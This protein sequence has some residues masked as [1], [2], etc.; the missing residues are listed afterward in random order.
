MPIRGIIRS[1]RIF[2]LAIYL[3]VCARRTARLERLVKAGHGNKQAK[4]DTLYNRMGS[5][6][7]K[8]ALQLQGLMVKVGQFLSART[9]VLPTSFTNELRSLQDAVPGVAFEQIRERIEAE[10]GSDLHSNFSTFEAQPLAAASLG[11]VHLASLAKG[12]RV[13]VKVL[14]P[15]IERLAAIDLAALRLITHI[16]QRYSRVGRRMQAVALFKEFSATVHEELDY[17]RE[18]E[19]LLRFARQFSH[20]ADI[21][22]PRCFS[23]YSTRRVL[24]MEY[25]EG[26][27]ITDLEELRAAGVDVTQVVRLLVDSYLEQILEFGFIHVDPHPGNLLVLRDG[28][29]CYLDFGMMSDIPRSESVLFARMFLAAMVRDIDTMIQAIDRLG[30]LQPYADKAVLKRALSYM[31]DRVNGIEI[32]RGPEFDDFKTEFQ[33]FL[34]DEPLILQARYMFLGRALGMVLGLVNT[35][36]PTVKWA[37]LLREKALPKLK[38]IVN[39]ATQSDNA[40]HSASWMSGISDTIQALFGES[41]GVTSRVALKEVQAAITASVRLPQKMDKFVEKL[42]RDG[43]DIRIELNDVLQHLTQQQRRVTR[44]SSFVAAAVLV[45]TAMY[46]RHTGHPYMMWEAFVLAFFAFVRW[47]IALRPI[48]IS[49]PTAKLSSRRSRRRHSVSTPDKHA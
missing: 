49:R 4:L 32:E 42:D 8:T 46:L 13:A 47:V 36:E 27:K 33:E 41:A 24:V 6:V 17:R 26:T 1:F 3:L 11:Q 21:V 2:A 16:L 34:H 23:S 37:P 19:H 15:G 29:L 12:G 22:V 45:P 38:A 28:R 35:L 9:D 31:V 14:R 48:A 5:H 20:R 30:F 25:I 10:L 7:R 44:L 18:T 39:E 40:T 43:L